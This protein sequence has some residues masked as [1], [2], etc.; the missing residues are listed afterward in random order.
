MILKFLSVFL[1]GGMG[2]LLRYAVSV[3]AKKVF[4]IPVIGTFIVNIAG[5]FAIGFLFGLTLHKIDALP[6]TVKLFITVGILG[7]L[8]T[9][10]TLTVEVFELIKSGKIFYGL[11]YMLISCLIGLLFTFG[12]YWTYIKGINS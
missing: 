7:G 4:M 12:G 9:F 2:A 10:S 11:F 5:C 6:H 1:G 3:S 8:T